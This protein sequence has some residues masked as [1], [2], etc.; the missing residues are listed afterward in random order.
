MLRIFTLFAFSSYVWPPDPR[1]CLSFKCSS[2]STASPPHSAA[3]LLIWIIVYRDCQTCVRWACEAG[4]AT[5][6]A[7]ASHVC[8]ACQPLPC[9]LRHQHLIHE[10]FFPPWG[11][12]IFPQFSYS[13]DPSV[14]FCTGTNN[15]FLCIGHQ[16]ESGTCSAAVFGITS[17]FVV[18]YFYPRGIQ[19]TILRYKQ[20]E[21]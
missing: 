3:R 10:H 18:V 15:Y 17:V 9:M 7:D 4:A 6:Q 20:N 13:M 5:S 14:T 16:S 2:S 11:V 8:R 1:A 19:Q 12:W 21:H